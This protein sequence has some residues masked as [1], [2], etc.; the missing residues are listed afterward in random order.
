MTDAVREYR[1]S[2]WDEVSH[3]ANLAARW[4]KEVMS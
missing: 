4:E 1:K 3:M 2:G